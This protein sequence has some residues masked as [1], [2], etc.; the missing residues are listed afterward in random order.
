MGKNSSKRPLRPGASEP[1]DYTT[2]SA[3]NDIFILSRS[4]M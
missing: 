2:F 3:S 4:F 1:F